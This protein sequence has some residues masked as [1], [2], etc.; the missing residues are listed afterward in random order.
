MSRLAKN[1][2]YNAA[3][4]GFLLL[5]SLVAVRFIFVKLG[6]DVLGVLYFALA[7]NSFLVAFLEMGISTTTTREISRFF[8][9][10][11]PYVIQLMQT[12]SFF[13]WLAYAI[14]AAAIY[15]FTPLLVSRWIS[16]GSMDSQTAVA[17]VRVIGMGALLTLPQI[18]YAS[19]LRG[20]Q[21]MEFPN[22]ID[23]AASI[24]QQ[25]GIILAIVNEGNA[26]FVS[27]VFASSFLLNIALYWTA[28]I[29]FFSW[30]ALIPRLSVSVLKRIAPYSVRVMSFSLLGIV[31][32]QIDK[33]VLS[34]L[35]PIGTF[36]YYSV[37]Y[38]GL[39]K[40]GF[41]ADSVAQAAFPS[42]SELSQEER[43]QELFAQYKKLQTLACA[44]AAMIFAL[45]VFAA[46]PIFSLVLNAEIAQTLFLPIFLLAIGFYMHESLKVP[47]FFSLAAGR[48]DIAMK[49]NALALGIVLPASVFLMVR[50]G[51]FGAGFAWIFY[52]LFMYAYGI[53]LICRQCLYI[54]PL[55]WYGHAAAI[56]FLSLVS[57]G[58]VGIAIEAARQPSFFLLAAGYVFS[59]ML[60]LSLVSV[61]VDRE[62]MRKTLSIISFVWR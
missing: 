41:F 8:T 13:Y 7:L 40:G 6:Q 30:R 46:R 52:N 48:P 15:A 43:T 27:Y 18:L 56:F 12:S 11:R 50:F 54:S 9:S 22:A 24:I 51:L 60:F 16:L 53:A 57:Y 34:R 31:H 2:I 1:I 33:I 49:A 5:L 4:Q 17:M 58:G 55:K 21:R 62:F 29:P 19:M 42:F 35:L 36:G 25:G 38:S 45:I 61:F 10:D 39:A 28:V 26:L 37:A 47:H 59:S 32:R 3:G 44:V 23:V 14:C 20:I